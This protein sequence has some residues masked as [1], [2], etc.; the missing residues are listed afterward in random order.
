[1]A[2]PT[3]L[4]AFTDGTHHAVYATLWLAG[5][6]WAFLPFIGVGLLVHAERTSIRRWVTSRRLHRAA[7]RAG[8]T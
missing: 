3:P 1:M 5:V 8:R 2:A 6:I 4:T 7:R